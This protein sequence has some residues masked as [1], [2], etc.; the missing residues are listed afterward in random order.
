MQTLPA[1]QVNIQDDFWGPKLRLNAEVAIFH[2]WEQLEKTGCIENFRL[3]A[4]NSEGFRLGF[5]FADSDAY[6]WLD[7]AA[8]IYLS[9][10]SEK[11]K[12][13][14]DDFIALI[15]RTQTEDGYIFTYNQFHFPNE[16]WTNLQIEHELYCCGHLIEAAVS[17]FGV[18]GE[19]TLLEIAIKSANLLA[20]EFGNAKPAGTPGHEEIELAL[21]QLFEVTQNQS[22]I[23]LAEH[24]IEQRG[25]VKPF[26]THILENNSSFETRGK[27]VE[28]KL[29]EYQA[30][31]PDH[32]I[33]FQL[34][35]DNV[36][37][38]PPLGFMRWFLNTATGKY[39]QQ[40]KPVRKQTVPVGHAVRFTYLE[41]AL[42]MLEQTNQLSHTPAS[43]LPTLEK[44]WDHM[45]ARRMYVTG[46]IG[47]LPNI[48]GFG[49]DFELDPVYSYSETCAAL[50]NIF[51]NW[52]MTK[53]TGKAKYADLTEWQLYNA[54][55]VG[56]AQD[57]TSYSYN[58]PL[59]CE[60]NVTREE[61]FK[62]P[63]C[64]SNVS[65]TWADLG[66]Y[67]FSFEGEA[68]WVHQYVGSEMSLGDEGIG[69][70]VEAGLPWNGRVKIHIEPG[71]QSKFTLFLRIPS[72]CEEYAV[73]LNNSDGKELEAVEIPNSLLSIHNLQFLTASGYDPQKSYYLPIKRN[74]SPGDVIELDFEIGIQIR[75]THPKVRATRG[76]VAVTRGPLVYCLESVDNPDIDIF[77]VQLD[78]ASLFEEFDANLFG[79]TLVLRGQTI[80]GKPLTFIPYFLWA[81]RGESQM[82][83]YV[84]TL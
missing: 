43:Y 56:L 58:N 63:C 7:A 22:Y 35:G 17:H 34:P 39:F 32:T 12:A 60:G 31:H 72:W 8:R 80:N 26:I 13:L 29:A 62:C 41:T 74:W 1:K 33:T 69:V 48:E 44:A 24:F 84:R 78:P 16:R 57:G 54:A 61:W 81:N 71:E 66:K 36:S 28:E 30:A 46:G 3:V 55:A 18:T 52:E 37:P 50:G 14:M 53:I 59:S 23:D 4:D 70:R 47:S 51:W 19:R 15:G 76:Q 67:V 20:R 38:K 10:P 25:R 6:K 21:I 42:A 64:P 49:R 82:T 40:H 65:R 2:Q 79:G 75:A 45:V 68:V 5:F 27:F 77:S 73:K 9:Y 83:V 11:L